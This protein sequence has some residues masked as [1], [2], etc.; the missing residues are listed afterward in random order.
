MVQSDFRTYIDASV[1]LNL[2]TLTAEV[3][4]YVDNAEVKTGDD[5][6]RRVRSDDEDDEVTHCW[7]CAD[8]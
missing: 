8:I 3:R 6:V 4:S 7:Q 5:N 2:A 1:H